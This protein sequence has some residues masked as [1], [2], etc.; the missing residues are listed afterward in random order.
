MKL[1]VGNW[2]YMASLA[3]GSDGTTR[4]QMKFA[5]FIP[6]P[7][8]NFTFDIGWLALLLLCESH[9][10]NR[11]MS[12]LSLNI[13]GITLLQGVEEEINETEEAP[14]EF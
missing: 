6:P 8:S 2:R 14:S 3:A 12:M 9:A 11:F 1:L 4:K 7:K 10:T 5:P 13:A